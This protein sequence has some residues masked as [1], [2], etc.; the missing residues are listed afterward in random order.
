MI[1][2]EF[3]AIARA[4]LHRRIPTQA[5]LETEVLAVIKERDDKKIKI[6]W[7]FSIQ[8][9]RSKLNSRYRAINPAN[10]KYKKT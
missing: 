6:N 1:E 2:I 10:S 4:C 3:S 5:Q 8:T 7:Q 9:A